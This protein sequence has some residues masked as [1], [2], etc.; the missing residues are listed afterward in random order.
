MSPRARAR[1]RVAGAGDRADEAAG[2]R[3][4]REYGAAAAIAA[5]TAAVL[6]VTACSGSAG[7]AEPPAATPAGSVA[8][9]PP[10]DGATSPEPLRPVVPEEE[11]EAQIGPVY[12]G[13]GSG[14]TYTA[15]CP[16]DLPNQMGAEMNCL[17]TRAADN[18]TFSIHV[19]V[20][21]VDGDRTDLGVWYSDVTREPSA[22]LPGGEGTFTP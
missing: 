8:A 4:A 11:V 18:S 10:A 16:G 19:Y 20:S 14:G 9:T 5:A 21:S 13:S 2:R 22:P 17:A 6:T 7:D 12:R 15:D 1:A 3:R